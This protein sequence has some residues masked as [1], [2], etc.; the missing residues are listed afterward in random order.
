MVYHGSTEIIKKPDVLHSYRLLDFGQGFYV[1]TV[2]EQAMRWAR[3][4]AG[5][6]KDKSGIVNCYQMTEDTDDLRHKTFSEDLIEWI[7]FVCKCRD[8]NMGYKEYDL[9]SG[10]VANDKVFRVVDLYRTGIWDKDRALKE[11]KAYPNYDQIAFITQKAIDK[12]LIYD[13]YIEV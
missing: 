5:L 13:S 10:K 4:K 2:K 7:D 12:L 1:T 3:R 8:G 6:Q 11:I 9:I